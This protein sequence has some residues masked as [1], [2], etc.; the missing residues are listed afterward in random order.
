MVEPSASPTPSSS[1]RLENTPTT[2]LEVYENELSNEEK[3]DIIRELPST[4]VWFSHP[5]RVINPYSP[6]ELPLATNSEPFQ[7][8]LKVT[9]GNLPLLPREQFLKPRENTVHPEDTTTPKFESRTFGFKNPR[10]VDKYLFD[11]GGESRGLMLMYVFS[12]LLSRPESTDI[13]S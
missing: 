10:D 2:P 7:E 3:L 11:K 6:P 13:V 9:I 1:Y 4:A 8:Q 5:K 12:L